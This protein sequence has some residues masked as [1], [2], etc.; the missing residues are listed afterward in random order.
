MFAFWQDNRR[1]LPL[2]FPALGLPKSA[3]GLLKGTILYT[4]QTFFD[5]LY[6]EFTSFLFVSWKVDSGNSP[7]TMPIVACP[8]II[9]GLKRNQFSDDA[10]SD[11][12]SNGCGLL[13]DCLSSWGIHVVASSIFRRTNDDIDT[14]DVDGNFLLRSC[15]WWC[16]TDIL[17]V[18][19]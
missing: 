12:L 5:N 11:S 3:R 4:I 13:L 19:I 10:S 6:L 8:A 16:L 18:V 2:G 7:F 17:L 15:M 1:Q 14:A 9:T